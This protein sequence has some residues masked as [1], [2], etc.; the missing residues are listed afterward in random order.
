MRTT[1]ELMLTYLKD[2]GP[3]LVSPITPVQNYVFTNKL[4]SII[5]RRSMPAIFVAIPSALKNI[6]VLFII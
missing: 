1:L 3:G 5:L 2:T 6:I 4:M